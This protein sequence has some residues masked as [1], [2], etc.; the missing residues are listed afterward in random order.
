MSKFD[1]EPQ[2]QLTDGQKNLR[3]EFCST[4]LRWND[5]HKMNVW[6]TDESIFCLETILKQHHQSYFS[7]SNQNRK[8]ELQ[9]KKPQK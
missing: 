6:W 1:A 9:K 4:F 5:A 8:I 2:L 7:E 3:L